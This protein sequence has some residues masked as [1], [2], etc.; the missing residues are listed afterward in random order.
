M[1]FASFMSG[2]WDDIFSPPC[3]QDPC[4][5]GFADIGTSNSI[6]MSSSND[7]WV[8]AHGTQCDYQ[9]AA[10]AFDIFQGGGTFD[11]FDSGCSFSSFD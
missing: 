4:S 1:S 2:L 7:D 8:S 10:E 3:A 6:D 5:T 9:P 11:A